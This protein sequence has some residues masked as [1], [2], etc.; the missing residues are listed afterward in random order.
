MEYIFLLIGLIVGL[1]IFWIAKGLFSKAGKNFYAETLQ[2]YR[3]NLENANQ[4]LVSLRGEKEKMLTELSSLKTAYQSLEKQHLETNERLG[5]MEKK[6]EERNGQY[7]L[8]Q[9]KKA[10]Q[11]AQFEAKT[12]EINQLM[13]R[14]QKMEDELEEKNGQLTKASGKISNLTAVNENLQEKLENQKKEIK[15]IGEKFTNEFKVLANQILEDKSKKFTDLNRENIGKL[16]EPLGKN[17]EDFKKKVEDT[18]DKESKQRFSLEEKIKELVSLNQKISE[19][20]NNLTRALKGDAKKQ[21]DW[22]EMILENILEQSGLTKGREYFVQGFIKDEAGNIVKTEDG[23]KLQPDVM[24]LYPD[25]RKIIID[26]KVSLTA[27]ER[28]TITDDPC[29][30]QKELANHIRSVRAHVENLSSKNYQDYAPSLDFVMLFI[31]IEPAYLLAIKNDTEL[32]NYAYQKRILLISPT[33][34]IAALKLLQDLWKREYQNR[35][36]IE[37]AE[38]G[39]RLYD[40]FVGF[41]D[42]L[43][44]I[45]THIERS[46]KA[47]SSAMN[48]LKEGSGNLIGQ[49]EKLKKLGVKASKSLPDDM[50]SRAELEESQ[51]DQP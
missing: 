12:K 36:A 46:E 40:K 37:I 13:A 51:E 24:V 45:G 15:E 4:E 28:Y 50:L 3:G 31:P 9:E 35:H 1:V 38:R 49:V 23:K 33:N 20:A 11:D 42:S 48:Q 30:Q 8:L 22:G 5:S 17:I 32:W 14:G 6:L 44:D 10:I 41:V 34:L 47:Y 7:T 25:N 21:G 29:E 43:Q 27:Y 26:S 16:L 2:E 18:Y 39:G 19:E